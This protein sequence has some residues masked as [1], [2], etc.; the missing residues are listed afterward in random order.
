MG[1]YLL[2]H[3][4]VGNATRE[5]RLDLKTVCSN[6]FGH[7]RK[8]ENNVKTVSQ[9]LL[10][11]DVRFLG[12][13]LGG[14]IRDLAGES[15][16]ER[17]ETIRKL[18][19]ERRAGDLSAE[20]ELTQVIGSLD[21][22]ETR[23]VTRAFSIF[24]DLA[25]LA[26]DR[27]RVRVLRSRERD[28]HPH[29][30]YESIGDA[31]LRMR[32]AGM[33]A[34]AVQAALNRLSIELV[35]TAHPSEAK[36]RSHRSKIRRMRQA[37]EELERDDLLPR[38][39]RK[40]EN[41]L[42]TEL[43]VLWQSEFLRPSHPTVLQEVRRGLSIAPRL[44]EVV[45]EIYRDMRRALS[46][47]YPET[48]FHLPLFLKFG[49]WIGGD[50]DGH[51]HVTSGVTRETLQLLRAA[52]IDAH[53]QRCQQLAEFLSVSENE[54]VGAEALKPRIAAAVSRWPALEQAIG[55]MASMETWRQWLTLIEWRLQQSRA[56]M[57][58]DVLPPGAYRDGSELEQDVRVLVESLQENRA[59]KILCEPLLEWLDLV[60]VFGLHMTGLDVR[61]DARVYREVMTELFARLQITDDFA[62]LAEDQRQELLSR[63]ISRASNIP[64]EG[65]SPQALETLDL[66]QLLHDAIV[67]FGPKC[68]GS[69]VISMT[70]VPSDMLTVLWL[71]RWAQ[72]V[73]SPSG[74]D[75]A[76]FPEQLS[77]V[78]LFEKIDDLKR[79][80]AT[81]DAILNQPLYAAHLRHQGSRQIVM[82]GY[83][84][85]TKDGGYLAACWG[86]YRAQSEL[87][88]VAD[89]HGV[90]LTF[91]HGRG[92]SLGRGGGPAARGIFSLP[93]DAL[94]GSL[95]LTEQGEV[96]AER[97]DDDQIAYRHLEQVTSAT[98]LASA[99]PV[100]AAKSSWVK[101]MER[102]A[103][104]SFQ[105]YRELVDQPGF[106]EFFGAATPIDEIETLNI[107]SRPARRRGQR[108]LADLRAIPWVFSWTQNRCLIPAWYGLG[109]VLTELTD[110]ETDDWQIAREMYR[111]WPFFQATIDNAALALAKADSFIASR[112]ADLV[113]SGDVRR[114][115]GAMI[116]EQR[117]RAH[118]A[119]L[120]LTGDMHLLSNSPWLQ[121]SID[122]RNPY[123]DPLNLIQ[124]ELIQRRRR[125]AAAD[126]ERVRE[127]LRLTVQGIAA[128]MRTTG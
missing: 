97:Y 110:E 118:G 53:L 24:F 121:A 8:G 72:V 124:I 17:V 105:V 90:D 40:L 32:D 12:D 96:L 83:S 47:C 50:R 22:S 27:H 108:S 103:Q 64:R 98:L 95:R 46:E 75:V 106:I 94:D 66:F 119:I 13:M 111:E 62:S 78:P 126:G 116:L 14:V 18:S 16:L 115:I 80:P 59:R 77:I 112:Y 9:E 49:S 63:T 73:G 51:P 15:A 71:W 69:H 102:I 82:I 6:V 113:E 37:L 41:Q 89:R 86:L 30:R 43:V 114:R 85:S 31:I 81:L 70:S 88:A 5:V 60:R 101:I 87:K 79:G 54:V 55:S 3:D 25:N 11:R 44:W 10:R 123:I 23:V 93:P 104:R 36:R 28:R 34:D 84:D 65:L 57:I 26:E 33:T 42:R 2:Q 35:F 20:S 29:P 61:Q 56:A 117:D 4:S 67:A 19:R 38:E 21:E 107:G 125:L 7:G 74:V 76:A 92:G 39:R 100:R 45:P 48:E 122:A 68:L 1:W 58:G 120:S 99:L 109:T 52:A 127:L 128:G 91:F